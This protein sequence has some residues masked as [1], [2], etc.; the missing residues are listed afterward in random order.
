[1]ISNRFGQ[2]D[3]HRSL[4]KA[5]NANRLADGGTALVRARS[6]APQINVSTGPLSTTAALSLSDAD[7]QRIAT[8][9]RAGALE[10]TAK[11]MDA[12]QRAL[13]AGMRT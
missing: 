4:L 10:G 7:V 13:H 3:R 6:A 2:A 8:A 9:V 11:G 5:I 1:M 12:N